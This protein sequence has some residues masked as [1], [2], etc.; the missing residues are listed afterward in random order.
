MAEVKKSSSVWRM[1]ALIAAV[2]TILAAIPTIIMSWGRG[3]VWQLLASLLVSFP[4]SWLICTLL[5]WIWR[6]SGGPIGNPRDRDD[7]GNKQAID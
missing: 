1:G 4:I 7:S 2:I 6:R 3:P 5:A